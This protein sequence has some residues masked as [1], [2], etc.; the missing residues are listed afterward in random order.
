VSAG[1]AQER[2]LQVREEELRALRKNIEEEDK[3]RRLA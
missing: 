2:A 3:A 1:S